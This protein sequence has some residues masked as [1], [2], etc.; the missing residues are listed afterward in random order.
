ME[1]K[2]KEV[3]NKLV[4]AK[5]LEWEA[6]MLLIPDTARPHLEVIQKEAK[7]MVMDLALSC[8]SGRKAG[9]KAEG[10]HGDVD[11]QKDSKIKKV[12]ID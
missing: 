12:E 1:D 4:Q 8:L 11:G 5:K 9:S 7:E 3:F 10:E 6:L 2:R